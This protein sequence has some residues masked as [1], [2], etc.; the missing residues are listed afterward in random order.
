MPGGSAPFIKSVP[1]QKPRLGFILYFWIAHPGFFSPEK[2]TADPVCRRSGQGFVAWMILLLAGSYFTLLLQSLMGI[3][4][5]IKL[6]VDHV[7][8]STMDR[9]EPVGTYTGRSGLTKFWVMIAV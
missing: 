5:N 6:K 2:Q 8:L 3:V 4:L 1:R 7:S 9:Q